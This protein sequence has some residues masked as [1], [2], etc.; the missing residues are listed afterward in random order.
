MFIETTVR[1]NYNV[2]PPPRALETESGG[3][4]GIWEG[5]K[6]RLWTN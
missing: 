6:K 3:R 5:E 1:E 4:G 2:L